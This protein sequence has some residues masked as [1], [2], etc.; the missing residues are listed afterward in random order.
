MGRGWNPKACR[1]FSAEKNI[2]FLANR[3]PVR[4]IQGSLPLTLR[5]HASD[6]QAI[7]RTKLWGRRIRGGFRPVIAAGSVRVSFRVMLTAL[8]T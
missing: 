5:A 8:S 6:P 4:V 3:A 1:A 2:R 7:G